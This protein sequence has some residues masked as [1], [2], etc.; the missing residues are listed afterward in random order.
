M[1]REGKIKHIGLSA[2][3]SATLRRAY[4]IAP[5]AA[6]Q[7]GY[8]VFSREIE[9]PAGS[10]ILATCRELGVAV[11][12]AT[13]LDRGLITNAF[14]KGEAIGEG[15]DIRPA[16]MPRFS[17]ENTPKNTEAVS[18]LKEIADKKGCTVAQLALSWLLKRGDDIFP[19]PGTKKIKYLEENWATLEYPLS[20]EEEAEIDAFEKENAIAG[21]PVPP[22]F[23]HMLFRDTKEET[24]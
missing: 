3:S 4:K 16:A 20:D 19:I 9:G 15:F 6:V 11:V 13:P 12:I 8:S 5:V 2:V 21:G 1:Y 14:T 24:A 7:T 17:A 10:D 23:A 18:K 22:Q